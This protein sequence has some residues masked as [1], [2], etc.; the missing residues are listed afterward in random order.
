MQNALHIFLKRRWEEDESYLST[1]LGYFVD[2]LY[3]LQLLIFPEGTNFDDTSKSKS[4]SFA[5][6]NGLPC[7]EYVLHPRVRGFTFC[8][9]K[10]RQGRLDAV[11]DV[12]VGYSENYC[13][14]ELDLLKGK[15]PDEIHF[16]IQRYPNEELPKDTQGLEEWCANRWEEKEHR[17]RKFYNQEKH[18]ISHPELASDKLDEVEVAVRYLM[19][20]DLIFWAAFG[21]SFSILIY[22]SVW[23]RWYTVC[24]AALFTVLSFCG[25]T[26]KLFL[27]TQKPMSFK[28]D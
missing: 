15:V 19:K 5:K 24:M 14:Q 1:V 13:F 2:V 18:F 3:P 27:Q 26:D 21:C 20:K 7:Y 28:S 22:L 23:F 17:L 6:K 8:V 9:E 4:D 12:T 11:H 25:G 10:L 16:H